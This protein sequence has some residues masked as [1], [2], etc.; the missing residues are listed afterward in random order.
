MGHWGFVLTAYG[1]VW[2]SILVY[3][4]ILKR[5][6]AKAEHDLAVFRGTPG[7]EVDEKK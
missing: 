2:S 7:A 1:I 4:T 3:V 5:R 6:V